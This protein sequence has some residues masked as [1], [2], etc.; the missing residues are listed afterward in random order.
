MGPT[1]RRLAARS[2]P[3][4]EPADPARLQHSQPIPE[5]KPYYVLAPPFPTIPEFSSDAAYLHATAYL[6]AKACP[7]ATAYPDDPAHPGALQPAGVSFVR[8]RQSRAES[9]SGA[10]VNF[11]NKPIVGNVDPLGKLV[12]ERLVVELVR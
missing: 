4:A 2:A 9:P 3:L 11:E 8:C 7:H 12:L 10:L 6:Y 1:P 5:A